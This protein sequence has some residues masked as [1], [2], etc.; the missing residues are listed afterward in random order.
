MNKIS[1]HI[2]YVEATHSDTAVRKGIDNTPDA[3]TLFKMKN[4]AERIFEPLRSFIG[5][6]ITI[7]SFFRCFLLNKLVGGAKNSQ[8]V[9]GEA[10]DLSCL[11]LNKKIFM[12]ILEHLEF[13]QL[14]WE[15]G[16]DDEP[17]WVHVSLTAGGN[18]HQALRSVRKNGKTIYINYK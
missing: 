12:F 16:D 5:L 18:R 14:I 10:F 13:D 17:S 11:G 9:T 3:D 15:F 1:E 7:N 2:A 6:A 4:I 8:H